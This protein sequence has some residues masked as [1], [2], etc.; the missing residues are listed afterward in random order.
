MQPSAEHGAREETAAPDW[1]RRVQA[2]AHAIRPDRSSA[3]VQVKAASV[4]RLEGSARERQ[5]CNAILFEASRQGQPQGM[6][7]EIRSSERASALAGP[8]AP[9][10]S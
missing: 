9:L 1:L 2:A 5:N 8:F 3:N 10:P 4:G 6:Q 7:S